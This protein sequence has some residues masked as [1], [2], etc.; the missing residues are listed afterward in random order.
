VAVRVTVDEGV[1][2]RVSFGWLRQL[3]GTGSANSD[4]CLRLKPSHNQQADNNNK[5]LYFQPEGKG[6]AS[7]LFVLEF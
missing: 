4:A 6:D 7:I 2:C 5:K 1:A 3:N